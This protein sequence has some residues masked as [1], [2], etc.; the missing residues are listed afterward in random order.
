MIRVGFVLHDYGTTWLGGNNYFRNLIRALTSLDDRRI[1]P[2]LFCGDASALKGFEHVRDSIEIH[3]LA[4]LRRGT[5]Q[6][7][8]GGIS[9]RLVGSDFTF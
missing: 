6:W 7:L 9:R 3:E 8:L 1:Q 2:V 5:A 4:P